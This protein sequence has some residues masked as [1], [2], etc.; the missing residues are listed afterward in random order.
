MNIWYGLNKN[1]EVQ[2]TT[3]GLHGCKLLLE[4]EA[5]V[6][7]KFLF[8]S[9]NEAKIN[10]LPSLSTYQGTKYIDKNQQSLIHC[11]LKNMNKGINFTV[12][13][14]SLYADRFCMTQVF[15][16]DLKSKSQKLER[17]EK[18][19]ILDINETCEP[20]IHLTFGKEI[21]KNN[22]VPLRR[23]L[24]YAQIDCIALKEKLAE[25]NPQSTGSS[26]EPC[27]S[28]EDKGSSKN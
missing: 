2:N 20:S 26:M 5:E 18:I 8:D 22:D 7:P 28:N 14:G 25:F 19:L 15:L 10:V 6:L 4:S 1:F 23:V 21:E 13:E 11:L 24:I 27:I 3:F 16:T 17:G 9:E 12:K